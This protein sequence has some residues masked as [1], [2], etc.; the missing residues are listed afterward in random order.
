MR[1]LIERLKGLPGNRH[2]SGIAALEFALLSPIFVLILAGTVDLGGLVTT[3]FRL[4]TAVAAGSNYVLVNATQVSST[5]GATL[6]TNV[7]TIVTTS[8]TATT[9]NGTVVVNDGPQVTVSGG[10]QSSGGTAANANL[11][12]CPTGTPSSLTWGSSVTCGSTCTSGGIAGKFVLI[13][14]TYTYN[15]IFSS[16]SFTN[17]GVVTSGALVQTQ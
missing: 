8:D 6:A 7:A 9:A 16:Y 3:K 15:A 11:C 12:Y 4:D 17:G 13:T 5:S 1:R 10:S 14:A 2:V